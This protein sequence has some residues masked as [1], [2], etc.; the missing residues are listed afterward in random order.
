MAPGKSATR[1]ATSNIHSIPQPATRNGTISNPMGHRIRPMKS[2]GMTAN[3]IIGTAN[4]LASTPYWPIRLKCKAANGPVARPATTDDSRSEITAPRQ[5][6]IQSGRS[7]R[8]N[9]PKA[10]T[11]AP[12]AA[13]DI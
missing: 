5:P 10:R 11:R 13:K 7:L 6:R 9:A 4:M 3:P 2:S 1:S 8:A 12:V